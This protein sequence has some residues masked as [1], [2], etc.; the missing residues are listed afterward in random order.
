MLLIALARI[1]IALLSLTI[2][3]WPAVPLE[4]SF[5]QAIPFW[6]VSIK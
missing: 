4:V 3:P 6:A 2:D 5:I 1:E